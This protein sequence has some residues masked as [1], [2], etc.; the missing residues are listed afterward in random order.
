MG[1]G[2]RADGLASGDCGGPLHFD[3]SGD[4]SL[5]D[6]LAA[7]LLPSILFQRSLGSGFHLIDVAG[8]LAV[9]VPGLIALALPGAV[10]LRGE[11]PSAPVNGFEQRPVGGDIER[12]NVKGGS[13]RECLLGLCYF[14]LNLGASV[15]VVWV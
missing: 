9:T 1:S 2:G 8:F 4:A 13:K 7:P 6:L 15:D 12:H 11:H 14:D 10:A 5:P 3:R